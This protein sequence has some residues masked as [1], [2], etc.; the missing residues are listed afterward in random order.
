MILQLLHGISPVRSDTRFRSCTCASY[1]RGTSGPHSKCPIPPE[2]TGAI[3]AIES[4]TS[5]WTTVWIDGLTSLDGYKGRCYGIKHVSGEDNK[6]I[7]Y[8][9]YPL[10]RLEEGY[11]TSMFT[12]IVGNVFGFKALRALRLEDFRIPIAYVK[13]FEGPPHGIQVERD[14]LNKYGRL[15]LG[16]TIKPNLRLSAKNYGRACYE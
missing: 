13:T 15:L 16:C 7:A 14:K 9:A 11:V 2:E 3:V 10:D 5:T 8:V 4:S 12:S 6:Y 1:F